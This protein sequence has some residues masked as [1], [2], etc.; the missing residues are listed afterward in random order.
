MRSETTRTIRLQFGID[1]ADWTSICPRRPQASTRSR[2]NRLAPLGG[3]DGR[4]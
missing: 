3:R 2:R 4:G 1:C